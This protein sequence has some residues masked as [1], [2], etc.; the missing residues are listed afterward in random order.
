MNPPDDIKAK[1]V[2][3]IEEARKY[4]ENPP[5][6]ESCTCDWVILPLL[7]AVGYAR[8]E[9]VSQAG[10][11][12]GGYPDYTILLNTPHTWYLEAKEWKRNLENGQDVVQA[13]NYA[14]ARGHR[15]VVLSNGRQW[16]LF[17]NHIQGVGAEQRL[18][19]RADVDSSA[20]IEFLL[21]LSKSSIQSGGLDEYAVR[22]R[23]RTVLQRELVEKDSPIV[24]SICSILRNKL[25]LISIQASDVVTYFRQMKTVQTPISP[26]KHVITESGQEPTPQAAVSR[27]LEELRSLGKKVRHNNP[28]VLTLPDGLEVPVQKWA[29]MAVEVVK[30]LAEHDKLPV[31]P[32]WPSKASPSGWEIGQR[33]WL[34]ST[35]PVHESGREMSARVIDLS[36]R[37]V[38]INVGYNSSDFVWY[39]CFLCEAVDEAPSRF[40]VRLRKPIF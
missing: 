3:E 16:L 5:P 31:L 22:S 39:L 19:A 1:L 14:N 18:V 40:L 21:A 4:F 7:R 2:S 20:F 12:G 32:F 25:G 35:S 15:W 36:D 30:W 38:Y 27:N 8:W 11:P 28:E 10:T 29:E 17:D 34:L 23:L 37:K 33:N 9:I 24:R 26:N 6:N 13:L